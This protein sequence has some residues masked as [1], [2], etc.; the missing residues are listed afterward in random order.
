MLAKMV[1]AGNCLEAFEATC[2]VLN[3][4]SMEQLLGAYRTELLACESVLDVCV[5]SQYVSHMQFVHRRFVRLASRRGA[6]VARS[7][8]EA[9]PGVLGCMR[10]YLTVVLRDADGYGYDAH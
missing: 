10:P 4:E 3:D 8:S 2:A 7:N 1:S 9:L 6:P 5:R